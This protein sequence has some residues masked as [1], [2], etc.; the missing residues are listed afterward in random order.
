MQDYVTRL[1]KLRDDAEDCRLIS[2]LA[3]D[4]PKQA[5]FH[6]L[7]VQFSD[8]AD[9]IELAILKSGQISN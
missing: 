2:R 6:K 8:L 4:S 5:L 1:R 9:E 7:A 3:T